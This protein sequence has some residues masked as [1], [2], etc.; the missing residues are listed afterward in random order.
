MV[1]ASG[2]RCDR[3]SQ[4]H[5]SGPDDRITSIRYL[6]QRK[7]I[8]SLGWGRGWVKTW[9]TF[10]YR[11]PHVGER[12]AKREK[13]CHRNFEFSSGENITYILLLIKPSTKQW[14][15]AIHFSRCHQ[16]MGQLGELLKPDLSLSLFRCYP[17]SQAS[18]W[19]G[20]L[21]VPR[22]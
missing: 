1:V 15:T 12:K 14:L 13:F 19:L 9:D 11:E 5:G 20:S 6:W 17:S 3:R 18:S 4:V 8:S 21:G 16:L 2:N 10:S 22:G 7:N